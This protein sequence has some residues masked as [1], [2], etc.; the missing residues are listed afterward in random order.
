MVSQVRDG[1]LQPGHVLFQSDEM[2]L[3]IIKMWQS[4]YLRGYQA[5]LTY[6]GTKPIR[7][8]YS[9]LFVPGA[10]AVSVNPI[11]VANPNAPDFS[12][13]PDQTVNIFYVTK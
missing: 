13:E 4:P 11:T 5:V 1:T 8:N 6:H 9:K 12:I 10:I 3:V 2:A 7:V